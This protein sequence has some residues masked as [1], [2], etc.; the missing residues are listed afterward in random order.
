MVEPGTALHSLFIIGKR[1]PIV[2]PDEI[3]EGEIELMGL[4]AGRPLWRDRH[5]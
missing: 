1:W 3:S 2:H 5:C 4:G